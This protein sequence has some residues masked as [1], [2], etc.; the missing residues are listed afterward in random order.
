MVDFEPRRI[1]LIKPSALGDI[2]HSLPVLAALRERFP[3]AHLAWV[4]NRLYEPLLRGHPH[5]DE[6]IP[7]DRGR[8]RRSVLE[9][10]GDFGRFGLFV[11]EDGKWKLAHL[12]ASVIEVEP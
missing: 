12:H 7:F 5:L 1:V 8:K 11:L 9:I 2:M 4:V 6:I 10:A 3:R